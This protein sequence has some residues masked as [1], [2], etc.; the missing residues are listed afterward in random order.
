MVK[1]LRA[2]LFLT[3]ALILL[4][5]CSDKNTAESK[6]EETSSD[7]E[8][9]A[10]AVT[11]QSVTETPAAEVTTEEAAEEV[12]TEAVF[13]D[14]FTE[15]PE[16]AA[17]KQVSWHNSSNGNQYA[18][19]RFFD[20]HDNEILTVTG[21]NGKLSQIEY[22]YEYNEDG[23]TAAEHRKGMNGKDIEFV[24]EYNSDGTLARENQYIDG[25]FYGSVAY[26][27][28][29]HKMA[30]RSE[31]AFSDSEYN[32][33]TD[34]FYEYDEQGRVISQKSDSDVVDYHAEE[35]YTYDYNGNLRKTES[36]SKKVIYSYDE[37][38]RLILEDLFYLG[39]WQSSV[40][41]EYEFY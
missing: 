30:V 25:E 3:A 37:D 5:G 32:G 28:D 24:Y 15:I 34:Y 21:D 10:A 14:N 7:V 16:N 38:N 23:S 11:A 13:P 40:R 29:N 9:S 12:T 41:Y 4:S 19:V 26:T 17:Y 36:D 39:S 33:A 8:A 31:Y 22:S 20:I 35:H 1:K 18:V 27:Y 2:G 6:S